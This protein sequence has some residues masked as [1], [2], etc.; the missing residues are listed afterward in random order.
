MNIHKEDL[1]YNIEGTIEYR[2]TKAEQFPGD[3]RNQ[4]SAAALKRLYPVVELMDDAHPAFSAMAF[5]CEDDGASAE[6]TRLLSQR[7]GRYGFDLAE[8]PHTFCQELITLAG[9][10]AADRIEID[11]EK[12]H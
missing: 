2:T 10:S 6:F 12:L 3:K 9:Q 7:L 5:A 1:L 11:G 4:E 8:D